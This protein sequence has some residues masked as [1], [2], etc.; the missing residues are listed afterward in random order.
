[1]RPKGSV[2]CVLV[3]DLTAIRV[4][5]WKGLESVQVLQSAGFNYCKGDAMQSS[6]THRTSGVSNDV[7][8]PSVDHESVYNC[9][10]WRVL[11]R[12]CRVKTFTLHRMWIS[13]DRTEVNK[14]DGLVR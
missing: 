1:M 10:L 4:C 6:R 11:A 9:I 3:R 7:S 14:N 5:V 13:V 2:L 12:A 8:T